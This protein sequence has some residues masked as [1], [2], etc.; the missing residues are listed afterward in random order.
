MYENDTTTQVQMLIT[1]MLPSEA[2]KNGAQYVHTNNSFESAD[3]L[4]DFLMKV[5]GLPT[6]PD[7]KYFRPAYAQDP[8]PHPSLPL[9]A[10]SHQ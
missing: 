10:P 3:F 7:N 9:Q 5:N 8:A 4:A 1:N 2:L 6:A